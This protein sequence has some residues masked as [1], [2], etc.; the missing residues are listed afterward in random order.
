MGIHLLAPKLK[1]S[2]I[3]RSKWLSFSGGIAITYIILRLLPELAAN[4]Q[5]LNHHYQ[6]PSFLSD[7]FMYLLALVGLVAFY[8][9][10][11]HARQKGGNNTGNKNIFYIHIIAFAI[12]NFLIG[13]FISA[14]HSP[15]NEEIWLYSLAMA[16]H[17]IVT[18][19][20]LADHH[21]SL[22]ARTGRWILISSLGIG[23]VLSI[24]LQVKLLYLHMGQGFLAG[25]VIIKHPERRTSFREKK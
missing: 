9:F 18:D 16:F 12:Y 20:G 6:I 4:Q 21:P 23:G 11:M 7:T 24:L 3:P 15:V 19:Y 25:A 22:Y 8:G 14:S 2:H 13:Y 5:T 10:E 17:L 1:L